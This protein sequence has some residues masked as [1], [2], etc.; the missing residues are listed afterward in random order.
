MDSTV[1]MS[2]SSRACAAAI[3][4]ERKGEGR[5]EGGKEGRLEG[6]E[7]VS[8]G[9]RVAGKEALKTLHCGY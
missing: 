5:R 9:G 4:S 8:D 3:R 6:R 2:E 7:R 1:F